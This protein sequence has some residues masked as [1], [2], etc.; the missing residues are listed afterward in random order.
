MGYQ[1]KNVVDPILTT[2]F[3][4][5]KP[6]HGK[7]SQ[8]HYDYRG[9]ASYFIY[10]E[11]PFMV[12]AKHVLERKPQPGYLFHGKG[13]DAVFPLR[14]G[15]FASGDEEL[16][17]AVMGC[18][19]N[20]LD[21]KSIIPFSYTHFLAP[22]FDHEN[23]LYY[24]NGYPGQNAMYMPFLGEFGISGNPFIA[25]AARL[26]DGF[27]SEKCFA[28]EYSSE[29]EPKGMSGAPI[30]NMRLHCLNSPET[31]S[32]EIASLA[33]IIHRWCPEEKVII[34]TRTEFLRDFIPDAI[35]H[36]KN[37]YRWKDGNDVY[38]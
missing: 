22:S 29:I 24:C 10:K 25:K 13:V 11:F 4:V 20:A 38:S 18:F 32:P 27:N 7:S 33:G 19:Q 36:L 2:V 14:S 12:T 15:W 8:P 28:V 37:K 6:K 34:A 21:E 30:W 3:G 9:T 17:I 16:D 23:A 1:L 26:P 31:W 35:E 5:D